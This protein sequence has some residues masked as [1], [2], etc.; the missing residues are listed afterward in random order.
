M[1][2]SGVKN[3]RTR[4]SETIDKKKDLE[5][6]WTNCTFGIY[7]SSGVSKNW[8]II[9]YIPKNHNTHVQNSH[10]CQ[11]LTTEPHNWVHTQHKPLKQVRHRWKQMTQ[12]LH[13]SQLL[14][15]GKHKYRIQTKEHAHPHTP[16]ITKSQGKKQV[17]ISDTAA[18]RP[19][20][21]RGVKLP[22]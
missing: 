4:V 21:A 5:Q 14:K 22:I 10:K 3:H 7:P 17:S 6:Y 2:C 15:S 8:G 11:L 18:H 19:K 16:W 12:P 1:Y 13:I 20:H 9:I